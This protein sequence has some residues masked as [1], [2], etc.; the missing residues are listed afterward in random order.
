MLLVISA[1]ISLNSLGFRAH[2]FSHYF[3]E[4]L[5]RTHVRRRVGI[6]LCHEIHIL[7]L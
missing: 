2:D 6:S 3:R 5:L 4:M 7:V 1:E